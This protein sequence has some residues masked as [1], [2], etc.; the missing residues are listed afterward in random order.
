MTST[1]YKV[2]HVNDYVF[3]NDIK[4]TVKMNC[5]NEKINKYF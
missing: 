2:E 5:P 1:C 4:P 3:W